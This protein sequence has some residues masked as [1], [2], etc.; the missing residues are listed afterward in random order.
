MLFVGAVLQ[1]A[2]VA[3]ETRSLPEESYETPSPAP[4]LRGRAAGQTGASLGSL[5]ELTC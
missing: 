3:S 5:R 1:A 4:A 2:L